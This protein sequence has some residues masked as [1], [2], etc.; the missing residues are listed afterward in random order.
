MSTQ[1]KSSRRQFIGKIGLFSLGLP[2]AAHTQ[3]RTFL[4]AGPLENESGFIILPYLESLTPTSCCITIITKSKSLTWLEYGEEEPSQKAFQVEYGLRRA[5]TTLF[6][7]PLINLKPETNYVYRFASKPIIEF[8]PYD[9]TFGEEQR[10]ETYTFKT[11]KVHPEECRAI[12][13]ND[14]HHHAP[15]KLPLLWQQVK[16]PVDF[17]VFNGDTLNYI[18]DEQQI[19]N[20]FF[21]PVGN[22][23]STHIPTIYLRGNHET[24]GKY[25]REF[26]DYFDKPDGKTYQSFRKGPV[27]WIFLDTGEDKKDDS[28]EYSGMVAFDPFRIEQRDWLEKIVETE[29]FKSAPFRVVVMHVPPIHSDDWHG[30]IHTRDLFM[31]IF[32]AHNIDSVITGHRHIHA[33]H[34]PSDLNKFAL[35][36]GGGPRKGQKTVFIDV[37]ANQDRLTIRTIQDTGEELHRWEKS[38]K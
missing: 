31:P 25:A 17:T 20:D 35:F 22:L 10:T 30:T 13:F 5:N 9:M 6:K 38:R 21:Q 33:L 34:P 37:K 28:K 24:R 26:L 12:V 4:P 16:K 18:T 7:I 19:V 23:F 15:A 8:N 2:I 11:P 32:N 14:L 3:A 1:K 29:E 36:I 27:Y